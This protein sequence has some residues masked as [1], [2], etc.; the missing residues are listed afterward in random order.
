M[1]IASIISMLPALCAKHWSSGSR[2]PWFSTN[3]SIR[4]PSAASGSTSATSSSTGRSAGLCRTCGEASSHLTNGDR[5]HADQDR[6][7][8][9]D[10]PAA[11]RV[12]RRRPP[13]RRGRHRARGRRR[14]RPRLRSAERDGERDGRIRE[15]VVRPRAEP[16]RGLG[17]HRHPRPLRR[18]PRGAD[19]EA[20]GPRPVG[21]R[22]GGP[23]RARG[24]SALA[25]HR[26]QGADPD[27]PLHA[28]R[29]EGTR[30]R[31]PAAG[32]RASDDR[33][34]GDRRDDPNRPG[35]ARADHRRPR[36][37]QVRDRDRHNHQPEGWRRHL[38]LRCHRPQ[39]VHGRGRRG[40][41][42]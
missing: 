28:P 30:H 12:L 23:S 18:H 2:R 15:R 38:R 21:A 24:Q 3:G 37:R 35:P 33:R 29:G 41:P 22:R 1:V 6:R 9:L 20:H 32:E 36:D 31:R 34:Q 26:R 39:G 25:A 16:R 42:A 7:D 14:H 11:D 27:D 10:H 17:R 5:S 13:R 40:D 19:R 8:Q 4:R